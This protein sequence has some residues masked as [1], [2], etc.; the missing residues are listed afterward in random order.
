MPDYRRRAAR[1]QMSVRLD[2]NGIMAAAIGGAGVT[3]EEVEALAPRT[4]E[5]TLSLKVRRS[6]GELA[7]Y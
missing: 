3:R 1:E 4:S 7:F 5:M 2:L 6:A